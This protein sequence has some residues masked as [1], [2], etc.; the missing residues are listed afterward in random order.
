MRR[1]ARTRMLGVLVAALGATVLADSAAAAVRIS[2][3]S[4]AVADRGGTVSITGSGFGGPNVSITVGGAPVEVVTATGSRASFRVPALAPVGD[5][6]VAARNPGGQVGRI[7]LTVR[8]DGHTAAVADSAA[9]VSAPVGAAGGTIAVE[10]MELAIPAGAVPEGTEI[11]ATPLRSLQG[12]PFAAAP[13]GVKLEPSGLVLLQP[14]TLTLPRPAGAG[15]LVGFGF[16]GDGEGLRLVPHRAD[17]DTVQLRD[18]RF[19]GAGVMTAR[20]HSHVS[21]IT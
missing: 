8:F 10:G 21:V 1:S 6:T 5:V 9:A 16:N 20:Q 14:A 17:G 13:V 3:I 4:P 18:W 12:S 2:A 11:T 15:L 19:C 7:G